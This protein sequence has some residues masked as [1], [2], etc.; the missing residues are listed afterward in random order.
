[1]AQ[2]AEGSFSD[3]GYAMLELITDRREQLVELCRR[4]HVRTLEL[5]GSA[6]D[7]NFDPGRSDLDF[8]VDFLPLPP[9]KRAP[10][11]F[12]LLQGLQDLYQRKID[13]VTARAIRNPYFLKAVNQSRKV[14]YA[15]CPAK[16]ARRHPASGLSR[17]AIHLG[18]YPGD[19]RR[20]RAAPLGCGT[21]I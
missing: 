14:L 6:A 1:M 2:L 13:L 3:M 12:G 5:F 17:L 18:S 4:H 10:A 15:A 8:L 21:S 19:L 9:G 7:G 20:G 11:Y 16:T